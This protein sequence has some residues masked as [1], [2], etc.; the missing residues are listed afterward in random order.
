MDYHEVVSPPSF[1]N[2]TN[3]SLYVVA[4]HG[5]FRLPDIRQDYIEARIGGLVTFQ[6][7]AAAVDQGTAVSS[8]APKTRGV[9]CC[10][11]GRVCPSV[12]HPAMGALLQSILAILTCITQPFD[13]AQTVLASSGMRVSTA[14]GLRG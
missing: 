2:A 7:Y 9:T 14:A 5:I 13:R 4:D 12:S 10:S 6:S 11:T 1:D 8:P 3:R